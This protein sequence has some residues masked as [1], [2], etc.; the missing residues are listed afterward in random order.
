VLRR[1]RKTKKTDVDNLEHPL[2]QSLKNMLKYLSS[3]KGK[4]PYMKRTERN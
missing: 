2:A 4:M 3:D 1:K